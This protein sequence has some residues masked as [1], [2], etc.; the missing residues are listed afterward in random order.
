V[1]ILAHYAEAVR[2]RLRDAK[3][4][5]NAWH[6]RAGARARRV[7][8]DLPMA[9]SVEKMDLPHT[10]APRAYANADTDVYGDAI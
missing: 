9:S 8:S 10:N 4:R 2:R 7:P 3:Q 6:A 1:T 5:W